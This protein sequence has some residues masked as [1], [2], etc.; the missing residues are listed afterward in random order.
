MRAFLTLVSCLALAACSTPDWVGG[1]L[2]IPGKYRP[3]DCAA[4]AGLLKTQSAEVQK[5]EQLDER[6][7]RE[8]GGALISG[9]A[10]GV[11]TL[12]ARGEL[13]EVKAEIRAKGCPAGG[14]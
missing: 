9:F 7:R 5:Y 14:A 3:K 13:A 6:A 11:D 8:T 12:K 4:L 2:V 10:Y 1:P